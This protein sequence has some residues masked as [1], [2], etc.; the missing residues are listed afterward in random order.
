V[1]EI[2]TRVLQEIE[3]IDGDSKLD[4]FGGVL[5]ELGAKMPFRRICVLTQY[6]GTLYYLAAEIE[7][8]GMACQLLHG[9]LNA[10]D[11]HKSL[12]LILDSGVLLVGTIAVMTEGFALPE[13]TDLILYDVP[14]STIWLQ[15]VLGRFDRFGRRSQLT[16]HV[17]TPSNSSDGFMARSID[18]LRDLLAVQAKA[19]TKA[20]K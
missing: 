11:R 3:A 14:W 12:T 8:R 6:L 5:S 18:I 9:G 17:L 16:V 2:A 15:Q 13:I 20:L 1:A 10:E 19:A 7:G 4:A